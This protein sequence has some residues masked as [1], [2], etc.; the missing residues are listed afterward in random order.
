MV[1]ELWR[2]LSGHLS[3]PGDSL[4]KPNLLPQVG[5]RAIVLDSLPNI[6]QHVHFLFLHCFKDQV[7]GLCT[8]SQQHLSG[9][10]GILLG[11][12]GH[13]VRVI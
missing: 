4:L 8:Y 2:L 7:F 13:L 11:Y 9:E 5:E 1:F 12:Q 3:N 6:V 10:L